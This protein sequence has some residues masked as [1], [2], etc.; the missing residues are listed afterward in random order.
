MG[1]VKVVKNKNELAFL[2]LSYCKKYK[3]LERVV[4]S[5]FNPPYQDYEDAHSL[6]NDVVV[7]MSEM[8]HKKEHKEMFCDTDQILKFFNTSMNNAVV[9]FIR[10]GNAAK[11]QARIYSPEVMM[12]VVKNE[13]GLDATDE[14]NT[15][16]QA[17][18]K[19]EAEMH[20]VLSSAKILIKELEAGEAELG[21]E[22]ES[23]LYMFYHFTQDSNY[24]KFVGN[25][26]RSLKKKIKLEVSDI[27]NFA[28]IVKDVAPELIEHFDFKSTTLMQLEGEYNI[29][30]THNDLNTFKEYKDEPSA[31][32][33]TAYLTDVKS[34]RLVAKT[35]LHKYVDGKKVII[36]EITNEKNLVGSVAPDKIIET[37]AKNKAGMAQKVECAEL[38]LKELHRQR[39]VEHSKLYNLV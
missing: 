7:R 34:K 5:S 38:E 4:K 28:I 37:I 15:I 35:T 2:I 18:L 24:L 27:E 25:K 22:D 29:G 6:M 36:A 10:T 16:N 39:K 12:T 30:V 33:S 11:R 17:D 21:E 9:D 32:V 1:K 20:E 19:N 8:L 13:Q 14:W 31:V 26:Y 23:L 3:I